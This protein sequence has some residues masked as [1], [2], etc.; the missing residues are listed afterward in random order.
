MLFYI[1]LGSKSYPPEC[2]LT[3]DASSTLPIYS[4]VSTVDWRF[5]PNIDDA[6]TSQTMLELMHR[7][8]VGGAGVFGERDIGESIVRVHVVDARKFLYF[9]VGRNMRT[10]PIR[11]FWGLILRDETTAGSTWVGYD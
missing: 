9:L 10:F 1:P 11:K 2:V 7:G 4:P 8:W 6:G 5:V 3:H